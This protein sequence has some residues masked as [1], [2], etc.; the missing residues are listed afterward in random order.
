MNNNTIANISKIVF[1]LVM[2]IFGIGH[3]MNAQG[4]A[5]YVPSYFPGGALWVYLTGAGLLLAAVSML[6]GKYTQLACYLLGAMLLIFVL[7]IH[8][9][10]Y[11][12]AADEAAKNAAMPGMM[13]DLAL[14]AASFYFGAKQS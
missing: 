10:M 1:A 13:K 7:S 8:L 6:T 14:A 5:G 2:A 12:H 11:L 3:F 9:P 4:M